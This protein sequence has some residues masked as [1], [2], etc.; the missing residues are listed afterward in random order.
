[1]SSP[2][3]LPAQSIHLWPVPSGAGTGQQ[4]MQGAGLHEHQALREHR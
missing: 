4:N 1:M 2:K 3:K